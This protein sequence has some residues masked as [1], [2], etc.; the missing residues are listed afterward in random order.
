MHQLAQRAS[1]VPYV[2][3]CFPPAK[4]KGVSKYGGVDPC[5]KSTRNICTNTYVYVKATIIIKKIF[6]GNHTS[7]FFAKKHGHMYILVITY[8][9]GLVFYLG[10]SCVEF[11]KKE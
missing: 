5:S 1:E 8:C 9:Y 2:C 4:K 7:C 3:V 11:V 10:N 6:N